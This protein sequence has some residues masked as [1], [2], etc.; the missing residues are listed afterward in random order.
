MDVTLVVSVGIFILFISFILVAS[1]NYFTRAPESATILELRDKTKNLFDIFFGSGGVATSERVTVDL[2]RIPLVLEERNGTARTSE[3]VSA[4]V[5]FDYDCDKIASWNDTVRVYDQNFVEL[6]SR[7][8]YQEFCSSQWL[9]TSYI[10]FLV[11]MTA[12]ERKRVY[13][14]S[15]NNSNTSAPN[16]NISIRGYW[17]FDE[18]SGT[19][20]R[21]SSGWQNN[22]TLFNGSDSCS[23]FNCPSWVSGIYSNAIQL[24]GINDYVNVSDSSNINLTS[25]ILT[26]AAWVRLNGTVGTDTTG[27]IISK[28]AGSGN[29]QFELLYTTDS[30]GTANRFRFDLRTSSGLVILYTNETFASGNVWYHVAGVYNSTHMRIFVNGREK[31]TTA[32]TG[33]ITGR[34]ADV[35]IGRTT[36]GGQN[37]NG[38]IDEVRIYNETLTATQIS[39]LALTLDQ[40]LNV[41]SFPAE[42]I[43]AVS[44]AKVQ[45]LTGRDYEEIRLI[46]GG[47]FNFRIEIREKQ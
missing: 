25:N 14:Y 38:T 34:V 27:K 39:E 42:N 23:A 28:T 24:D 40:V 10:T 22:G 9:N 4:G 26:L 47:D 1:V 30:H 15:V 7:I 35:S 12:S 19:F 13:A 44:A 46:L 20:A 31:N 18:T 45:E 29:E 16:H 33:S 6:P 2:N 11:N 8:S 21:D 17:K 41:R 36:G 32:Q 5:E 37:F 3:V 43:A